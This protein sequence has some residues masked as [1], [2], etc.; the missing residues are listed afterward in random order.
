MAK[1]PAGRLVAVSTVATMTYI[2]C[3]ILYNKPA[4]LPKSL[5]GK[6]LYLLYFNIIIQ[7]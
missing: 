5:R 6:G 2:D 1:T 3:I 7:L 4:N